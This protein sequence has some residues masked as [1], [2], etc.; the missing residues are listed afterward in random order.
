MRDAR[1]GRLRVDPALVRGLTQP[2]FSRRDFLRYAGVGAGMGVLAACGVGGSNKTKQSPA[3]SADLAKIYGDGKPAGHL[4]FA[5]WPDYIDVNAKG[6]SPTLQAF[7]EATGIDVT[8]RTAVNDNNPFL[9]KIIPSLQNGQDTGYDLIVITNGGPVER[10]IKLGFLT[11]LDHD[12]LPNFARFASPAVKDPTYDPGNRYTVAWQ[13]GFTAIGYNSKYIDTAPTTFG[14][15]LDPKYKGKVGMFGN[16]QDLPCPALAF[17]G[18]DIQTSTP[19][20][21]KKTADMLMRHRDRGQFR[22]FYDQSYLNELENGNILITQAWSGDIFIAAAAK[23]LGGDGYPEMKESFPEEGAVLWT[24][25]QC[26]PLHAKHPVDAITFMDFAY[27]PR[28][29]AELADFIWFVS[30]VPAA[31]DQ[32][33]HSD[34][35]VA[36]S[37]L[38]FPSLEVQAKAHKYRVF[39]DSDE[40]EEWNSAWEPVFSS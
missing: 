29:A 39:R 8:Y 35:D 31:K 2:R 37:P 12:F 7:T 38:V 32:L 27:K 1:N 20:Q 15:L 3:S 19:D 24:D 28:I 16:N 11:P 17:M 5:N 22:G 34:P 21:W 18:F 25:N 13:S 4:D 26:I 33:E 40:E 14:D 36:N 10:M 9:A 30:P 6:D 23:S